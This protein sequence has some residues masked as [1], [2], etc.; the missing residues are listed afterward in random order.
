VTNCEKELVAALQLA[1]ASH[2]VTL[3]SDPPQDAWKYNR[4]EAVARAAIVKAEAQQPEPVKPVRLALPQQPEPVDQEP[5]AWRYKGE[6][7]H[8]HWFAAQA[9]NALL[10]AH[11]GGSAGMVAEASYEVAHA[12]IA[13]AKGVTQVG[14]GYEPVHQWRYAGGLAWVDGEFDDVQYK[15]YTIETRTLWKPND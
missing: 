8:L 7:S 2:G 1:L 9:M 13:L 11:P 5:I 15:H 3:L 4:V 10:V 12:M 14:E 6:I